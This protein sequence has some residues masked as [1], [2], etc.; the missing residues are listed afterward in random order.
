[1]LDQFEDLSAFLMP[2]DEG[3]CAHIRQA[4]RATHR[5]YDGELKRLIE[6]PD[7]KMRLA[8]VALDLAYREGRP[9]ER[10]QVLHAKAD[11]FAEMLERFQHSPVA[12][13]KFGSSLLTVEGTTPPALPEPQ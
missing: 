10:A 2:T 7:H 13:E 12:Q 5:I 8:A 6:V 3:Q 9:V 11:D 1:M 4:K